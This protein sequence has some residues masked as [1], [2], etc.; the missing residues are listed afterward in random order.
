MLDELRLS[1]DPMSGYRDLAGAIIARA[2][3]DAKGGD[4]SFPSGDPEARKWLLGSGPDQVPDHHWFV[5]A[6]IGPFTE[7]Q[8]D[9]TT[10]HEFQVLLRR[11]TRAGRGADPKGDNYHE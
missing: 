5:L 8:I 4:P 3:Q 9:R 2:I 6:G 11:H 1:R 7:E 10:L